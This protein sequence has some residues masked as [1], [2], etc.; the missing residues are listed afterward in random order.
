MEGIV[1]ISKDVR[2]YED[3]TMHKDDEIEKSSQFSSE[4][5]KNAA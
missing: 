4:K 3:E 1:K 2:G 5:A